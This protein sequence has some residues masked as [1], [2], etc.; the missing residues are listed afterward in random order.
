ML[1]N[2]KCKVHLEYLAENLTLSIIVKR[3]ISGTSKALPWTSGWWLS[4]GG[5][6]RKLRARELTPD[7]NC[8]IPTK[9]SRI[10]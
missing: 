6:D 5:S 8:L 7:Q 9:T 1:I 10:Y 2:V 4:K 3:K